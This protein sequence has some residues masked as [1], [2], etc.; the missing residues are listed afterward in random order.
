M[1]HRPGDGSP[2]RQVDRC[3][4]SAW[5]RLEHVDLV[6]LQFVPSAVPR[7][8]PPPR[9]PAGLLL[10]VSFAQFLSSLPRV[11]SVSSFLFALRRPR[12]QAWKG[13]LQHFLRVVTNDAPS[14]SCPSFFC[15]R[16][17]TCC[18]CTPLVLNSWPAHVGAASWCCCQRVACLLQCRLA[19]EI[20]WF[21]SRG[22][23]PTQQAPVQ[24]LSVVEAISSSPS[25]SL[26]QQFFLS[27]FRC[28]QWDFVY[29]IPLYSP[30]LS[31]HNGALGSS[32]SDAFR[33]METL[34][35]FPPFPLP[36]VS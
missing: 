3:S 2:L 18:S 35:T 1:G 10:P 32:F 19:L 33:S 29:L 28:R 12:Q 23:S 15:V 7:S 21:S 14:L 17:T 16:V 36:S 13:L 20:F 27:A 31:F 5:S 22:L 26:A 8:V 11:F 24:Q 6:R 34:S 4:A 25:L 9:P 30:C